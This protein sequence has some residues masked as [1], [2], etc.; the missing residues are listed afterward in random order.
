VEKKSLTLTLQPADY[1][2]LT[3][4]PA[5]TFTIDN[6]SQA[7]TDIPVILN[8]EYANLDNG[9]TAVVTY[10]KSALYFKLSDSSYNDVA[11]TLTSADYKLLPG[12][13]YTDFSIAQ[14]LQW[15]PYKFPTP[16]NNE[17]KLLTFTPYPAT[18]TPPYSFLYTNGAWQQIYTITPAEYTEL[19]LGKYDQFGTAN[20]AK[21]PQYLGALLKSDITVQDTISK[22]DIEYVSFNYYS[23]SD[24]TYQRVVPL[25][26]DGSNYTA[27]MATT[28]T[29]NFIKTGGKWIFVQ[30]LPV[31]SYTLDAADITLIANS[32]VGTSSERTNLS[33][34]GDFESSWTTPDLDAAMIL[35]LTADFTSPKQNTNYE[36][37]YK[38][39]VGG[40]DVNT[41]LIFQWNGTK[42]VAQQ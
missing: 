11:Y 4:Y 18:L 29:L 36:V 37:T 6:D 15:L 41:V 10:A 21:L 38:A 2:L 19:G 31:I 5:T 1:Q 14:V 40:S 22:G 30:P 8:S 42:W 34:Y 9:S 32:T 7:E 24:S 17:L 27:P 20:D 25:V 12:N 3:G 16:A 26:Y 28:S 39:Y 35:V 23:S 33:S 13:K